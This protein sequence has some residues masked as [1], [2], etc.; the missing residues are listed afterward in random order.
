M[1]QKF[2]IVVNHYGLEEDEMYEAAEEI[3]IIMGL[4]LRGRKRDPSMTLWKA[5]DQYRKRDFVCQVPGAYEKILS[6]L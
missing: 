4:R 5:F 1:A 6:G 2:D 3:A